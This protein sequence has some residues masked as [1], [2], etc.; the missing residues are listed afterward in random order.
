[1][2]TKMCL[3]LANTSEKTTNFRPANNAEN[4]RPIG[5][6][7]VSVSG[8]VPFTVSIRF[9]L[10]VV[11]NRLTRKKLANLCRTTWPSTKLL[12][13]FCASSRRPSNPCMFAERF[14]YEKFSRFHCL[15]ALFCGRRLIFSRLDSLCRM[16]M[17]WRQFF[18]QF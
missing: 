10:V 4:F 7:Y 16:P 6:N 9:Q 2:S 8:C 15:P 13:L 5:L 14:L 18:L 3:G 12:C 1:M 11:G 17:V